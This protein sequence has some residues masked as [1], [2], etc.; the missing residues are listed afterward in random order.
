[1]TKG[2]GGGGVTNEKLTCYLNASSKFL[3][4]VIG[5]AEY[6][7]H[8][9]TIFKLPRTILMQK[10]NAERICILLIKSHFCSFFF[11]A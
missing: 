3:A 10:Y 5:L 1:M 2:L 9:E 7:L 11:Q 6:I 4:K 8:N